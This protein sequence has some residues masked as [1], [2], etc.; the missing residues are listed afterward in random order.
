[1][2]EFSLLMLLAFGTKKT[3]VLGALA[4]GG[5][6]PPSSELLALFAAACM[7]WYV[8]KLGKWK[9]LENSQDFVVK[10]KTKILLFV[11]EAPRD[12]DFGLEDYITAWDV[13]LI[14]ED[15]PC[16]NC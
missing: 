13:D 10:T 11:L 2:E 8:A 5:H 6:D 1:M 4:G 7:S 12:Q 14:S 15:T 3:E 16:L 9:S